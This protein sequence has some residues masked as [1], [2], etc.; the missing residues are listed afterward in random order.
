MSSS[1]ATPEEW[2]ALA[3]AAGVE[4]LLPTVCN[5]AARVS[6]RSSLA[7]PGKVPCRYNSA[8]EVSGFPGWPT[9][10]ATLDDVAAWSG[11][12]DY[13]IC[14]QARAIRAIDVDITDHAMAAR[15]RA[16]L[17]PGFP[18]RSRANSSK[19][20]MAFRL[21][22]DRS[23]RV[24]KTNHGAIELL[25]T[26][27]QF[28]AAG[29]HESGA[30]YVWEGGT[31]TVFPTLDT[32]ESELVWSLLEREFG[33]GGDATLATLASIDGKASRKTRLASAYEDDPIARLLSD[34]GRVKSQGPHGDL[35]IIC[36]RADQHTADS[37]ESSTVYYP[38][39]TGGYADGRFNCLH[40]HCSGE[41]QQAFLDALGVMVADEFEI[42]PGAP[43]QVAHPHHTITI[44]DG[45]TFRTRPPGGYLIKGVFP[46]HGVATIYGPSGS[47]KS[48]LALDMAAAIAR[49]VEWQGRRTRAGVVIY[50]CAEG[51]RGF[52]PRSVAYC[53]KHGIEDEGIHWIDASINMLTDQRVKDLADAIKQRWDR[54]ALLVLDTTAAMTPGA[55][56][57]SSKDMGKF[58]G[59][60]HHLAKIFHCLVAP[61]HHTGKDE[62]RGMRGWSGMLGNS[63]AVLAISASG[64]TRSMVVEKQKDGA[65]GEAFGFELEV[66]AVGVDD[67]G[68]EVTSC[69]VYATGG[70]RAIP[71]RRGRPGGPIYGLI[72]AALGGGSVDTTA[73]VAT[74]VGGLP[75]ADGRDRRAE[76][77]KRAVD[78]LVGV[79]VLRDVFGLISVVS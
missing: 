16:M 46:A 34:S 64:E 66:I 79:G 42:L 39:H 5:P 57:N 32:F 62:S 30:R 17:P 77:V 1:G 36:P 72:Y 35:R 18:I 70:T 25:A 69:T 60:C 22:E 43:P 58:Y 33:G 29:R 3:K 78:K 6:A 4:N 61:I 65:R 47:G 13:G 7:K 74:V 19:F 2:A 10:S 76:H 51:A 52:I 44:M 24:I 56:E 49:G 40:A 54:I 21:D 75:V 28:V 14:I 41:P 48:F 11:Q 68:D 45:P 27:Q 59:H 38:A 67:D 53:L 20:L 12:P 26:G 8:G 15:V 55:D 31:P 50:V 63:D 71:M 23:K 9:N 37:G 73:L